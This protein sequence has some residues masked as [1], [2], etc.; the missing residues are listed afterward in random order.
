MTDL[1]VHFLKTDSKLDDIENM[2]Q[3]LQKSLPLDNNVVA[4]SVIISEWLRENH[5]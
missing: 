4:A 3:H 1:D 5:R 2:E